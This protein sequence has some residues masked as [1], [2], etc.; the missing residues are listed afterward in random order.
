VVS[1]EEAPNL[2]QIIEAIARDG[3][4]VAQEF[5][6]DAE[7]GDVRVF[8]MD[9]EPLECDGRVAAFRRVNDSADVRSNMHAGGR[10]EAVD[11]T[12]EMLALV[13]AVKPKLVAD[14]MFLVGLDVVGDKI[15]EVN[16]F[17]PGGLGSS[18][19]LYGAD[20]AATVIDALARKVDA[21]RR[22]R[23]P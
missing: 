1:D 6:P 10:A 16:V 22:D 11:L 9:G 21:R 23:V 17:S 3:Y 13:D 15:V 2:D 12:D 20:F 7:D 14:G 5:L 18:E 8:V 19:Q 4:V